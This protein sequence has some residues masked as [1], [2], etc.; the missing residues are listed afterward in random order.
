[1]PDHVRIPLVRARGSPQAWL[2]DY[3]TYR[4]RKV[5]KKVVREINSLASSVGSDKLYP[6]LHVKY[7]SEGVT[8]VAQKPNPKFE[9]V[10]VNKYDRA[11]LLNLLAALD[12]G[13][14]VEA[15]LAERTHRTGAT[16]QGVL[17]DAY[18]AWCTQRGEPPV[19]TKGFSQALVTA[20]VAKLKRGN[21]GERYELELRA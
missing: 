15:W 9:L 16:R 14:N 17:H 13:T 2:P 19:G 3:V 11:A 4:S 7:D 6:A 20:G 12:P 10:V 21:D 8:A 18:T 1:M 5:N